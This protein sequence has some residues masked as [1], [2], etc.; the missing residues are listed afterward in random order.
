MKKQELRNEMRAKREKLEPVEVKSKSAV[1]CRRFM[2]TDLYKQSK[3]IAIYLSIRNEVD[4]SLLI[5]HA[6]IEQ[7]RLCVPITDAKKDEIFLSEIFESEAFIQGAF[8]IREPQKTRRIEPK[9]VDLM[10]VPGLAFD[11][12]GGRVGWGRAFYD[13]LIGQT[14]ALLVGIG[15]E[16][17]LCGAVEIEEH[18][19]KMDY[20]LTESELVVCE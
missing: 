9:E 20:I 2:E 16:F 6:F 19:R 18:D 15:Y 14:N 11:F 10:L 8:G 5:E 13:R 3:C 17:Q 1:I 7:K 12:A 4:L